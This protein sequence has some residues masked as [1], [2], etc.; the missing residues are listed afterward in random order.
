MCEPGPIL[1][2]IYMRYPLALFFTVTFKLLVTQ[3]LMNP[4]QYLG[5]VASPFEVDER[6]FG[7]NVQWVLPF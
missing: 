6:R 7:F 3:T 4:T 1:V 2:C 5:G